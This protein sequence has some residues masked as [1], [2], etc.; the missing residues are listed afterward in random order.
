MCSSHSGAIPHHD[1]QCGV[2]ETVFKGETGFCRELYGDWGEMEHWWPGTAPGH[3]NPLSGEG[4]TQ[5]TRS[6]I[7]DRNHS[8]VGHSRGSNDAEHAEG[9]GSLCIRRGNHTEIAKHIEAGFFPNKDLDPVCPGTTFQKLQQ[10]TLA[11]KGVNQLGQFLHV[12]G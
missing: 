4:G 10:S 8:L 11:L 1:S 6:H 12:L 9:L 5:H 3:G 7:N 2:P